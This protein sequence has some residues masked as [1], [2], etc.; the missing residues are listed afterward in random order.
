M[1]PGSADADLLLAPGGGEAQGGVPEEEVAEIVDSPKLFGTFAGVFTPTLLTILGVIMYLRLGWVVGNAGLLGGL[2]I[3]ALA[4][5]IT[6]CTGLSLSSIATNTRLGA[7]G[8]YAII[9]KSL[10][11]EVGGSVG[12]PLYLSQGLAVAMYVFGFREGWT[13]VFPDH[14]ALLVD[15]VIFGVVFVIAYLS[16]SLAFKIQYVVM[17]VIALS[18]V[19]IFAAPDFLR[20]V[21]GE[22]QLWGSYPGAPEDGFQGTNFWLVFA[23]FFPAAT[24]V[25]A[26][27]NMSGELKNPRKSIPL[28]TLSAIGVSLVIYVLLMV[29]TVR[30]ATPEELVSNYTVM[31]DK[32]AW[33]PVVLAGLLGATFSSALTSLVG[34]PRIIQALGKDRLVPGGAWL[35]RTSGGEP[36]RAM[37]VTGVIVLAA[38]LLR[39]LN[40][41]APMITMFF[42]ITYAVIN[43]VML[44]EASL[45]LMSFRPTF[46]LPR[47]VPLFGALGCVFAMFIVN[48]TFGLVAVGVVVGIYFWITWR[49]IAPRTG[50]VRSG[51]FAAFAEWAA[52]KVIALE[53]TA[54]RAW[55]PSLLVPVL[56]PATL[57]GELRLLIDVCRPEGSIKLLGVATTETV[58]DLTPRIE[59]LARTLRK[60]G[61]LTTSSV[62]DSAGFAT[63][64]V[65]G[66]QALRSAFFAPNVLFLNLPRHVERHEELRTI[67]KETSRLGVGVMLLALHAEAGL[68][69]SKTVNLWVR[70]RL[71]ALAFQDYLDR[72]DLNLGIL[73]ALRLARAWEAELNLLTVVDDQRDVGRAYLHLAELRDLARIPDSAHAEVMVG[74]FEACV[75]RAPQSDID[76]MGL[77]RD[78]AGPDLEFVAE[79]VRATRSACLFCGSSGHENALA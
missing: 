23:V 35:A 22:V 20:G 26:G 1:R 68:G 32:A 29:W 55:K 16:A 6:L 49:G 10:G 69:M 33:G 57:R 77:R 79:M 11:F 65:T 21:G 52:G 24:G 2:L 50:T 28:G 53:M 19:S 41:I 44:A 34:A 67:V 12:V 42:L 45:G 15:L 48:P 76:V 43:V 14:P 25:M 9:S 62:I 51:I 18:L 64:V 71:G 66:V 61:V 47:I 7:G 30:A 46:Q 60:N 17:A 72:S 39:D 27:A 3:I 74:T 4:N 13:W 63:G 59:R 58:A 75:A 36:R 38:L 37:V 54:S 8:P 31:I 40:V 78:G 5:G 70:P 73:T 56:D